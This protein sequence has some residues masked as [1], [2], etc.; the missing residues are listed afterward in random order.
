MRFTLPLYLP[1]QIFIFRDFISGMNTLPQ[2]NQSIAFNGLEQFKRAKVEGNK[3][4]DNHMQIRVA[5]LH[6]NDKRLATEN[7][8]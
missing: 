7:V 5:N 3:N 1:P 6:Q 2:Y 4:H 8:C